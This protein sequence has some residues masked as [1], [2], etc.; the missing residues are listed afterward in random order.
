MKNEDFI[1]NEEDKK[2]YLPDNKMTYE[3]YFKTLQLN[4]DINYITVDG[5]SIKIVKNSKYINFKGNN[6]D[7]KIFVCNKKQILYIID[8]FKFKQYI[9]KDN[10]NNIKNRI[11]EKLD[12]DKIIYINNLLKEEDFNLANQDIRNE[13]KVPLDLLSLLFYDYQ[14]Y[15]FAKIKGDFEMTQE[16]KDFFDKLNELIDVKNFI[17]IC[18]PKSIG[19]TTSLLYYLK[20]YFKSEYF[21]INLNHCRKLLNVEDY[22]KLCLC[23]CKELFNCLSF[24][25]VQNFYNYIYI[26]KYKEIM[27]VII[28]IMDYLNRNFSYKPICFVI[29]QYKEKIDKQYK[30]IEKI[31]TK[32][33]SNDKFT[34]ILCSSINEYD[35][36]ISIR[37]KI[38]KKNEF[39]L[40]YLFINKL[41]YVNKN[42]LDIFT[43]EEKE[44]LNQSGNLYLYYQKILENKYN[45]NKDILEIKKEI[46]SH[47]IKEINDYF[48][49]NDNKKKIDMIRLIHDNIEKKTKFIEIYDKLNIF[50]L[51]FFNL[52]V[53]DK[54]LFLIDDLKDNTELIIRPSYAIVIDCINQIFT[55]GKV[56]LRHSSKNEITLNVQKSKKSSELEENFN[57]FLWIYNKSKKLYG[58]NIID[59]VQISSLKDM[60]DDDGKI[61]EISTKNLKDI[62]DSILIIQN[63]QNAK[64]FDTAILKL[65][66][67][68]NNEKFYEL[69]LFQ[70]TLK[71]ASDERLTDSTLNSDKACLKYI[72][73][74]KCSIKL[75]NI[76]F[77][78]V[79]DEGNLDTQTINY[80]KENK[81]NYLIFGTNFDVLL[82]SKIDPMIK[83]RFSYPI[84]KNMVKEE[85][86]L[87]NLDVDYSLEKD[88]LN[89]QY[90][91][92]EDFLQKKRKLK[93]NRNQILNNKIVAIQNYINNDF[94]NNEI[95][96]KLI[97]EELMCKENEDIVGISYLVDKETKSILKKIN[98]S[99]K[100]KK[101]LLDLMRFYGN[102]LEIIK[103]VKLNSISF[104]IPNY[105]CAIIL[106]TKNYKALYDVKNKQSYSLSDKTKSNSIRIDGEFYLIKLAPKSM[107]SEKQK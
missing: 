62:S 71:K 77:S 65:S 90:N 4:D 93:K 1:F 40:D 21:Y 100:E 12:L 30:S 82:D 20:L 89:K 83:A 10:N 3:E 79:F 48:N 91:K 61:I 36:R 59:R 18:G 52:S 69:Y 94:R 53:S 26:K 43:K 99:S 49:E 44:L 19:K 68:D 35:F 97:E 67:I 56:E 85:Y 72:F 51:K 84:S 55:G 31:I 101:N 95:E 87:T 103:A 63:N 88:E 64:H 28:D 17:P 15:D 50:P 42:K 13:S 60:K 86:L 66:K 70:E 16:R 104:Y 107:L 81:I 37:R 46:M 6:Y 9:I 92:L 14:K 24:D 7:E 54:N 58:C 39:Y 41:I 105:D 33:K 34:V 106:V 5:Y 32:A 22:E 8:L 98:L 25:D 78:Y 74:L 27:D 47:I 73:F 76:Y 23:I 2:F 38:D 80:C 57:D 96:E 102:D 75:E 45:Q 11:S 29:D